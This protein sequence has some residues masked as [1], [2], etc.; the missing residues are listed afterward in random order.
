MNCRPQTNIGFPA[1]N[2]ALPGR[3]RGWARN[4]VIISALLLTCGMC[5]TTASAEESLPQ[6]TDTIAI[7]AGVNLRVWKIEAPTPHTV[8]VVNIDLNRSNIKVDYAIGGADPD[9]SGAYHT[10]NLTVLAAA[11]RYGFDLAVNAGTLTHRPESSEAGNG[12]GSAMSPTMLD[13][14]WLA[15]P[16]KEL[17]NAVVVHR[18]GRF[19]VGQYGTFPEDAWHIFPVHTGQLV[20]N[21]K[22]THLSKKQIRY[23]A[24]PHPRTALG[25]D[26]TGRQLTL[27]VVDGRNPDRA[28]G[29]TTDSLEEWMMGLGV[30]DAVNLW[31]G[32]NTALVLRSEPNAPLR[33]FNRP[34]DR[35]PQGFVTLRNAQTTLGFRIFGETQ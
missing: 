28:V 14:E 3:G 20:D 2:A 13:G 19:S 12:W 11:E 27:L 21:G 9:G 15:L 31:G 32:G 4:A 22:R 25:V 10:T 8:Y 1:K 17:S 5:S 35:N 23:S 24:E 30:Y 18:D 34:S 6:P 26:E 16:K 29:M 7:T 33:V